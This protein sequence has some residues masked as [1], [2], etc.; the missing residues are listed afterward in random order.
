VHLDRALAGEAVLEE[1]LVEGVVEREARAARRAVEVQT[2]LAQPRVDRDDL[3]EG[4]AAVAD[5]EA[6][7]QAVLHPLHAP[8]PARLEERLLTARGGAAASV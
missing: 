5:P 8:D 6:V 4:R 7:E 1:E 2:A 3:V